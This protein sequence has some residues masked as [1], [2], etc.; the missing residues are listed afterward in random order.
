MVAEFEEVAGVNGGTVF[1]YWIQSSLEGSNV[2]EWT[3]NTDY[4]IG[5][6]VIPDTPNGLTYVAS[7][8]SAP[9]PTW[10]PSTAAHAAST[11]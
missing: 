1:H 5:D 4:Q 2:N 7:R 10:T 3:A 9:N 6:V 11:E 8:K